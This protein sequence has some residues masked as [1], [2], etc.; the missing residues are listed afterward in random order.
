MSI[1]ME[2]APAGRPLQGSR[3]S[4]QERRQ[5]RAESSQRHPAPV[6]RSFRV[7]VTGS[8]G[9]PASPFRSERAG[10]PVQEAT[11]FATVFPV[12]LPH[13]RY[14]EVREG[15]RGLFERSDPPDDRPRSSV[16][17]AVEE[18]AESSAHCF[19]T[20]AWPRFRKPNGAGS[21]ASTAARARCHSIMAFPGDF[22]AG[23]WGGAQHPGPRPPP[24][25][26]EGAVG[27]G[28]RFTFTLPRDRGPEQ[29]GVA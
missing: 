21:A 11:L 10:G 4:G 25:R 19:D 22:G 26:A 9:R 13:E 6:S 29:G 12:T 28:A 7:R 16:G 2:G 20:S 8:G 17:R 27:E 18:P 23:S 14:P 15:P 3:G 24:V 5:E 1:A